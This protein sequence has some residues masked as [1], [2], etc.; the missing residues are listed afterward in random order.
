MLITQVPAAHAHIVIMLLMGRD[1]TIVAI[2]VVLMIELVLMLLLLLLL[3]LLLSLHQLIALILDRVLRLLNLWLGHLE[4][5]LLLLFL[6]TV[7]LQS[8]IALLSYCGRRSHR[9]V[10]RLLLLVHDQG[11][12]ES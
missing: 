4:L 7:A 10:G 3:L 6:L 5:L 12:G 8:V 9:I 1:S 2:P 11:C